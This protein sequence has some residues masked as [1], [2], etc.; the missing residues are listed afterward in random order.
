MKIVKERDRASG[1]YRVYMKRQHRK[2]P[3]PILGV[4]QNFEDLTD[5]ANYNRRSLYGAKHL[6]INTENQVKNLLRESQQ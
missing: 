5:L 6:A 1:L 3:V 4:G 2:I